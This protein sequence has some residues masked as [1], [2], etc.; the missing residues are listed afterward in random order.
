MNDDGRNAEAEQWLA[1]L[2]SLLESLVTITPRLTHAERD[3]AREIFVSALERCM[4]ES[5]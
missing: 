1:D 2:E 3:K 4:H 5:V